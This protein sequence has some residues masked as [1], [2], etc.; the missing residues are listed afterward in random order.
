MGCDVEALDGGT[1][2]E[3]GYMGVEWD[4]K[5]LGMGGKELEMDGKKLEMGG[6]EEI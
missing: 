6:K 4:G 1:A 2:L 3:M 5:E